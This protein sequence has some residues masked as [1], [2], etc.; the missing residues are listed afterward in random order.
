MAEKLFR[1][2]QLEIYYREHGPLVLRYLVRQVGVSLANDMLHDVFVEAA[3][4]FDRLTACD[5]PRGWLL[6]V[7]YHQ[8]CNYYRDKRVMYGLP[9][10]LVAAVPDD[11]SQLT[12][13]RD[14]LARLDKESREILLLRWYEQL[15]YE[16][17]SRIMDLPIGTVRSR[18]HYALN[19]L[20]G[21]FNNGI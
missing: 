5:S 1:V 6:K 14:S 17:I 20:R 19:K 10:E 3:S 16:E 8:V 13:L 15:S 4:H 18:L 21:E 7:A 2:E 12:E 11:G 9:S